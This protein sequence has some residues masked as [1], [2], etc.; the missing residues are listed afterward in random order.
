MRAPASGTRSPGSGSLRAE[1]GLRHFDWQLLVSNVERAKELA[2]LEKR[3]RAG[4]RHGP[5]GHSSS[6]SSWPPREAPGMFATTA[7]RSTQWCSQVRATSRWRIGG[8]AP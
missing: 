3:R 8:G 5:A 1:P 2:A 4:Q 6:A 7:G